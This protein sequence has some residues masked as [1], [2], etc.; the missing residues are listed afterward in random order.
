MVSKKVNNCDK[1]MDEKH[2]DYPPG[3]CF[4]GNPFINDCI[5]NH[6]YLKGEKQ[7]SNYNNDRQP[8]TYVHYMVS[9]HA[10]IVIAARA[11]GPAPGPGRRAGQRLYCCRVA[12]PHAVPRLPLSVS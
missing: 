12:R 10:C 11:G 8:C 2:A 3:F 7:Y 5:N 9:I 1:W 6:P 4:I